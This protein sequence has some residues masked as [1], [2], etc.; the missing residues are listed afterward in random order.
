MFKYPDYA[1]RILHAL[2]EAEESSKP[3]MSSDLGRLRFRPGSTWDALW[4]NGFVK[5][6][7]DMSVVAS[8][9]GKRWLKEHLEKAAAASATKR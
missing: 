8:Q 7:E 3:L 1:A 5:Q 4:D 9:R 6:L 2:V